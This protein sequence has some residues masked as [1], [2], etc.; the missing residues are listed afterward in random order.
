METTKRRET[1]GA[2]PEP[3]AR[4]A[5][6]DERMLKA[7]AEGVAHEVRNPLAAILGYLELARRKADDPHEWI[8]GVRHEV[9]RIDRVVEWLSELARPSGLHCA[10]DLGELLSRVARDLASD[11]PALF[12]KVEVSL[13]LDDALPVLESD[14]MSLESVTKTLVLEAA[15][16]V[17]DRSS[18]APGRVVVTADVE[19]NGVAEGGGARTVRLLV[20]GE[21]R[22]R[23]AGRGRGTFKPVIGPLGPREEVGLSLTV[24]G[25]TVDRL[26][27]TL[28]RTS[29]SDGDLGFRVTLPVDGRDRRGADERA[30]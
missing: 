20:T 7:L 30:K 19:E 12:S 27:G 18:G 8:T 15:E 23:S 16:A 29:P 24:A 26:G 28:E 9:G 21:A 13:R 14:P 6:V 2:V 11:R 25:H 1:V 5:R 22:G 3:T 4:T 17:A 10:V